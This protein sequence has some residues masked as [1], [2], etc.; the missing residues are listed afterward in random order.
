M[1]NDNKI[2]I[3]LPDTFE[4][5]VAGPKLKYLFLLKIIQQSVGARFR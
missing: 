4:M 3:F 5:V 1:R 2:N